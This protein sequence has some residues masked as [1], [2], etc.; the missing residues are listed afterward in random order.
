MFCICPYLPCFSSTIAPPSPSPSPSPSQ[1]DSTYPELAELLLVVLK[2]LL[3]KSCD[4][5]VDKGTYTL[6]VLQYNC[7]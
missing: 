2:T 4:F 5:T 6:S 7:L 1:V 3:A